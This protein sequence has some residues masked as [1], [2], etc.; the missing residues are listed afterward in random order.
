MRAKRGAS[1]WLW[2]LPIVFGLQGA[3][4][5]IVSLPLQRAATRGDRLGWLDA[6]G[7]AGVLCGVAFEA[8]ADRQLT[9]FKRDP[10]H[11]GQLM[12]TGLWSWSR[13]PNYFGDFVVWWSLYLLAVGS[14]GAWT[15]V[16][17]LIMSTLLLRVSGVTL[18]EQSM[19]QRPG[20]EEYAKR[21]SAFF[22]RPPRV[23]KPTG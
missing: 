8:T 9:L 20:W 21:T 22:P 5:W 7:A 12:T 15:V 2:S 16:S 1:W 4:I 11:Q 18:L 10:K 13:H 19:K 3:L 17:P 6:V 14:G 23:S